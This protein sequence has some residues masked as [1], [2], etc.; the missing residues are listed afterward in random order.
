MPF[1]WSTVHWFAGYLHTKLGTDYYCCSDTSHE[2]SNFKTFNQPSIWPVGWLISW[3]HHR[4]TNSANTQQ[5]NMCR[6]SQL[7]CTLLTF[8]L[9]SIIAC[10]RVRHVVQCFIPIFCELTSCLSGSP[11]W[12]CF[13]QWVSDGRCCCRVQACQGFCHNK[14][15]G[16]E[17]K[18]RYL[19][20]HIEKI[21]LEMSDW[22]LSWKPSSS[23]AECDAKL[24]H[25]SNNRFGSWDM[26]RSA[27]ETGLSVSISSVP[28]VP[29][30][31][32]SNLTYTVMWLIEGICVKYSKA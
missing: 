25:E 26:K 2:A 15:R 4:L 21:F 22:F 17:P 12:S 8:M 31:C 28:P 30:C 29:T 18:P 6:F 16:T 27:F 24:P 23:C 14:F 11:S 13:C 32:Y 5:H 20:Q 1:D 19:L 10:M 7:K 3:A 9:Q